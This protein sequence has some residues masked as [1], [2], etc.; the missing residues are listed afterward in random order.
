M[1]ASD[2]HSDPSRCGPESGDLMVVCI[3][4]ELY[5]AC[6]Y[7]DCGGGCENIG[8]CDRSCHEATP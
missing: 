3:E 1:T 7:P 4:G 2:V 6:E 8:S 5:D